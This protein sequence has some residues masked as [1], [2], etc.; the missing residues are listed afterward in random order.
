MK[1]IIATMTVLLSSLC[2][3]QEE[4]AKIV[5]THVDLFLK[6]K[7]EGLAATYAPKVTLMPGHECLKAEYGLAEDEARAKGAEVASEK[8]I[9]AMKKASADRPAKPA[10]KV[11]ALVK[12]LKYEVLNPAEG[13]FV[14]APSDPVGTPDGKLHF[15]VKKGDVL[16]KVLT[17]KGDFLLFQLRQ[18]SGSWKI[19]SEYID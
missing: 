9:T 8:I 5:Q 16:L 19:V 12:S 15:D 7:H 4:A 11:D 10:D 17:P 1:K 13:N 14:I 18:L 2:S 6:G 3:A